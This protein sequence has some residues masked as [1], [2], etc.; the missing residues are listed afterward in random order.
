MKYVNVPFLYNFSISL[1][2]LNSW[3]GILRKRGPVPLSYAICDLPRFLREE[4]YQV[5]LQYKRIYKF[6]IGCITY[7]IYF[8]KYICTELKYA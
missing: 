2:I 1:A 6:R 4:C 7:Y 5:G 3:M 8:S